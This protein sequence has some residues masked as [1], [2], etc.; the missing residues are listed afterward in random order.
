MF[1]DEYDGFGLAGQHAGRDDDTLIILK[2]CKRMVN[3]H[4]CINML[5]TTSTR[6]HS[7]CAYI[8]QGFFVRC[9]SVDPMTGK[10]NYPMNNLFHQSE[11]GYYG[12]AK[13]SKTKT[14]L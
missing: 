2:T 13:T 8:H 3:D 5:I 1:A 9:S 12:R 7:Q 4:S 10:E 14:T 6:Y 11:W